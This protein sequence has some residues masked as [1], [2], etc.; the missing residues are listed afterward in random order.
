MRS[1]TLLFIVGLFVMTAFLVTVVGCSDDEPAPTEDITDGGDTNDTIANPQFS[2]VSSQVED[3]VESTIGL[4]TDGLNMTAMS[5]DGLDDIVFGSKPPD[6]LKT[7]DWALYFLGQLGTTIYG[8]DSIQF[9]KNNVPQATGVGMDKLVFKHYYFVNT[10]DTTVSYVSSRIH[11]D[12]TF[13]GLDGAIAAVNGMHDLTLHSKFASADS[14]VWWD[15]DIQSTADHVTIDKQGS[16]WN[17]GCPCGGGMTITVDA[18]YQ[19]DSADPVNTSWT[20]DVTFADGLMNVDVALGELAAEYS[21]QM[22]TPE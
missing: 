12:L 16:N 19:K 22:C 17:S 14:T 7:G 4:F 11:S 15:F 21:T 9:L 2:A 10:D 1:R 6:S 8:L 13:S 18:T 3:F 5:L 20:F